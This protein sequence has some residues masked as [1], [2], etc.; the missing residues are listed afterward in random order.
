M[1]NGRA[2]THRQKACLS[3]V[4][5]V[6]IEGMQADH[7]V[8]YS[9]GGATDVANGQLILAETNRMKSDFVF[10][11]RDWQEKF[12]SQWEAREQ[13]VPFLLVAVPGGGKTF[14]AL[15]AARTWLAVSPDRRLIIIVPTDGLRTQWQDDAALF[16]I[17]LQSKEFA[18]RFKDGFHGGVTTYQSVASN[19]GIFRALSSRCE[20]MVI[21]D[22][23]HHCGELATFGNSI[24][25]AF[26]NAREILALS[27]TPWRSEGNKIPFVR[28][29]DGFADADFAYDY[30]NALSDGVVRYLTFAHADGAIKYDSDG[31][32]E[33]VNAEISEKEAEGRLKK[34][35]DWGGDFIER[36]IVD[37]HKKLMQI[38]TEVKDAAALAACIDQDHAEKIAKKI[39]QL[40]GCEP[41]VI[42]SDESLSNDEIKRFRN[43]SKEWLVTVRK[44]S[45]GTDIKR[46]QVLCYF[47]NVTSD[48]FFRQLVGRVSRVRGAEDFEAYV[49]LPADPRLIACAQNINDAQIKALANPTDES[50]AKEKTQTQDDLPFFDSYTTS[51]EGLG[52]VLI[53]GERVSPQ[54]AAIIEAQAA[55][56]GISM[57]KVLKLRRMIQQE[58][59]AAVVTI[60]KTEPVGL[61]QQMNAIRRKCAKLVTDYCRITRQTAKSDYKRIHSQFP[62]A[63]TSSL[64]QLQ[65][66]ERALQ[67]MIKEARR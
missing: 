51:H 14:A 11:P 12:L 42:V 21:F 64:E 1:T 16:G 66:K 7:V 9:A 15:E 29:K 63:S 48:L 25:Y 40:T 3:V 30:E 39:K 59:G 50:K 61:E 36:Q 53:A 10:T 5:D 44:V 2:F 62:A 4:Q 45:E 20:T 33:E 22:E 18:G 6:G 58:P 54:E 17:S 32:I 47:T 19:S 65:Y 13:G 35:L 23:I 38:R 34:L 28:Y 41:S 60:R 67:Q 27:G 24:S 57:E 37:A 43:C 46:L 55:A 8:P 26:E 31:R 49:Y 56:V 52:L